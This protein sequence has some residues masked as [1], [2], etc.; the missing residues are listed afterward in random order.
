[1]PRGFLRW[2]AP[3]APKGAGLGAM[4]KPT[5]ASENLPVAVQP[6]AERDEAIFLLHTAAEIEHALLVQYLY[7][8]FSFGDRERRRQAS[9]GDLDP[10]QHNL[11]FGPGGWNRTITTIAIEEM[12]HFITVQNVLRVLGGP[13]N[14]DREDFP[15]RAEFYPFP[16]ALQAATKDSLAKYVAAEMPEAPDEAQYPKLR[17]IL[18]RAKMAIDAGPIN[19]VGRLF[20]RIHQLIS[21]LPES[22]F[23][24]ETADSHQ[25]PAGNW[26]GEDLAS[27]PSD[28][29]AYIVAQFGG[30]PAEAKAKVLNVLGMIAAQGEGPGADTAGSHFDLFYRI[31]DGFPETNPAYGPVSW[32]P[33]LPVPSNPNTSPQPHPS[34]RDLNDGRITHG[35]ALLWAQLCNT[36]YRMLLC[37][38][39]HSLSI[40]RHD[41]KDPAGPQQFTTIVGW[42]MQPLMRS[43]RPI[44]N[45]LTRLPLANANPMRDGRRVVAGAPFE[46]P[47]TLSLPDRQAER[48]QWHRDLIEAS[49]RLRDAIAADPLTQGDADALL[50]LKRI[51]DGD[52]AMIVDIGTFDPA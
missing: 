14:L 43:L 9:G 44:S 52:D 22:L 28:K 41:K 31:Y 4:L 23:H 21:A 17:E 45:V 42:S 25:A 33:A 29:R 2:E 19:R 3:A 34:G 32:H 26:Q 50:V 15:F 38:I 46:L 37:S 35:V 24:P 12:C 10:G 5:E 48:W 30:A 8:A 6:M 13:S 16:F 27:L 40:D 51:K 7:A 1:M 18:E 47:Y 49:T 11:V 36:R 39:L 20:T